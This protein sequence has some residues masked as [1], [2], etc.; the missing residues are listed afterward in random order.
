[1]KKMILLPFSFVLTAL[2]LT[3][4]SVSA[5]Q[6]DG[7]VPGTKIRHKKNIEIENAEFKFIINDEG[8]A[9]SLIHKAS[10]QEC[11][12]PDV[13]APLFA[14]TQYTPYDNELQLIY[15][16][17]AKTFAAN[18]VVRNG[19]DLIVTFDLVNIVATIGLKITDQYIGFS[20]K[21]IDYHLPG[22]GDQRKTQIDEFTILQLPVRNREHFGEWLNVAWDE[23]VA[24][25]LLG[26]DPFAKI[27]AVKGKN[28]H[29]L[30]AVALGEIRELGVGAALIVT[31]KD[32]LLDRID[33][34][35]KDYGLPSGVASRRTPQYKY[36]Y[37]EPR[38]VNVNNIDEY[39]G[40]AKKGGFRAMQ[41]WWSDFAKTAG[42]FPWRPEYPNGMADLKIIVDKIK[43]AGIIPGIHIHYNKATIDDSYV[44][45][46]PDRR[47][48]LRDIFTL[49]T[50]A[51]KNATTITVEEN[52]E[53]LTMEEGRRILKA[54]DELIEYAHFTTT[55]PFQFTGCKRGALHSAPAAYP[56]GFKF[57]LLDVDTWNIFVRF[58]QKTSLQQEVAE[59]IAKF[60]NE[61]GFEFVYFDGAED[62]QPPYW[63]NVSAAQLKVY[64]ELKPFPVFSEGA[65][66]SHFSWHILTRGN[67]FDIFAPEVVK[68]A[69][70]K[71]PVAEAK[72]IANDFTAIDFGWVN[73]TVPGSQTIGMQPDMF[74]YVCSKAAAWDCPASVTASLEQLRSHPRTN[75]NLEVIRRWEEVRNDNLLSKE[76]KKELQDSTR[77]YFL[78]LNEKGKPE[79]T[80]YRQIR[81]F[82]DTAI[83]LRA[84]IFERSGKTYVVYWHTSGSGKVV[85]NLQKNK[86]NLY[87]SFGKGRLKIQSGNN[88]III[89]A[90][91]RRYLE[92]TL[93]PGDVVAAF[94][95]ARMIAE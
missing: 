14:V 12:A 90:G 43:K 3:S 69:T 32:H 11:L 40:Y 4:I 35:E 46:V 29:L 30:Q 70:R 79:L 81:N 21:K 95:N 7:P 45:P 59:R 61:A 53:N 18:S 16:A 62:V 77:E 17:K 26:T 73:F 19:D 9:V 87:S 57:G 82:K 74:E 60:Y 67:A 38:N 37:L 48:N 36:A 85:L 68:E 86:V 66:K 28:Y 55:P 91:D 76:Q 78:L 5:N 33:R 64:D 20:L 31:K 23:D 94:S 49:A 75:D 39:I 47:L 44:S 24:I 22:F 34:V 50:P 25:N 27:D 88:Q 93:P 92:T 80:E 58:D 15:P 6:Q 56:L 2:L 89:P 42:H 84:F 54:G 83:P 10:G 52:P 65:L 63:Y 72:Y 41:L 1:M 51:D 13:D 71:H 8:R